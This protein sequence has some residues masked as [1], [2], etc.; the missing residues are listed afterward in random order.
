MRKKITIQVSGHHCHLSKKDIDVLFGKGYKLRPLY[1]LSQIGQ[2]ASRET[3]SVKSA[4]GKQINDIRVLGPKRANSQVELTLTDCYHLKI[5]APIKTGINKD[6]GPGGQ[7]EL[8]GPKGRV[9]RRAAMIQN[10]HI[11]CD[12]KTAK[13]LGLKH[14]DRVSVETL[15]VRSVVW[16][17][18]YVKVR[19]DFVWR[20]HLDTDEANAANIKEGQTGTVLIK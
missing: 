9:K 2:Y 10:R 15:G 11:H 17:N 14:K 8:I 18:V 13:T 12:L 1:K 16:H 4:K 5:K 20:M 6:T 7:I 3:I 19:S